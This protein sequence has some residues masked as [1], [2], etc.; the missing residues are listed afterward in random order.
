MSGF[1]VPIWEPG[2][3]SIQSWSYRRFAVRYRLTGE[4]AVGPNSVAYNRRAEHSVGF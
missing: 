3:T 1:A 2:G 4:S